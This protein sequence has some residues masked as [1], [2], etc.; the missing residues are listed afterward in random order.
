M[1]RLAITLIAL[2]I[3]VASYGEITPPRAIYRVNPSWPASPAD[4]RMRTGVVILAAVI[5][6]QGS[7]RDVHV[8][9]GVPRLNEAAIDSLRQWRFAPATEN[10]KPVAVKFTMTFNF[11]RR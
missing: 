11:R 10:G 5:T 7:I 2:T 4:E 8:L 1:R 6:E 9:K 3:A